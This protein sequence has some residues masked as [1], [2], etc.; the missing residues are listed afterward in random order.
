VAFDTH[1]SGDGQLV[2][3]DDLHLEKRL[4]GGG[5]MRFPLHGDRRPSRSE[6]I[7]EKQYARVVKEVKSALEKDPR[8]T[9]TLAKT[10]VHQINRFRD[11]D[12]SEDLIVKA[13]N[14]IASAF[15]LGPALAQA[16]KREVNGRITQASTLHLGSR[17]GTAFLVAQSARGA[18]IAR[19]TREWTQLDSFDGSDN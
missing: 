6:D 17:V 13:A 1:Q 14:K 18:M 5:K 12:I 15:D 16:M 19:A 7:T 3:V 9:E 4:H 2:H 10:I 11:G 8:L